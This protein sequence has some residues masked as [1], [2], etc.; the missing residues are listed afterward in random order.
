[1]LWIKSNLHNLIWIGIKENSNKSMIIN[2]V[3]KMIT[4][5]SVTDVNNFFKYWFCLNWNLKMKLKT[6]LEYVA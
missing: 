5:L 4:D 1:M 2:E 6:A 3:V